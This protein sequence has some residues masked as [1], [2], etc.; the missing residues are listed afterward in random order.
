[1]QSLKYDLKYPGETKP[2]NEKSQKTFVFILSHYF[3]K[4]KRD[5]A[6]HTFEFDV[7]G[8]PDYTQNITKENHFLISNGPNLTHILIRSK[9]RRIALMWLKLTEKGNKQA[10][11]WPGQR[12]ELIR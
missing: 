3:F 9:R 6:A 1:M 11:S 10:Y 4:Y 12:I 8:C 7:C 2:Y 5:S